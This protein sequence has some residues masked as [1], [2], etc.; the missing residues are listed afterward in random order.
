MESKRKANLSGLLCDGVALC[1][2]LALIANFASPSPCIKLYG[3]DFDNIV[4]TKI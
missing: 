3:D 4:S 2:Y 1:L